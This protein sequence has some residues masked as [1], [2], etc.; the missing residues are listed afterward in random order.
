[1]RL[2]SVSAAQ[3]DAF[4]AEALR[5]QV[6]WTVRDVGGFPAPPGDDG[7]RAQPFWSLRSR[8]EQVV[9]SVGAYSGCSRSRSISWSGGE[10]GSLALSEMGSLSA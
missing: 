1:M 10:D 3:A 2:M 7:R 4:Y 6:V 8:V 9:R 5:E